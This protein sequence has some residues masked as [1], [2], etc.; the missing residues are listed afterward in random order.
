M[1]GNFCI[2][3]RNMK[4]AFASYNVQNNDKCIK[5]LVIR[6]TMKKMQGSSSFRWEFTEHSKPAPITTKNRQLTKQL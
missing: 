6:N 4:L 3:S 2:I 5:G 1:F